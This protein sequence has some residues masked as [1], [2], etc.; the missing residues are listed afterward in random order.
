MA[1]HSLFE[2]FEDDIKH[3]NRVGGMKK[4]GKRT[5][6]HNSKTFDSSDQRHL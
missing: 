6:H 3:G 5:I 4:E 2:G 1:G